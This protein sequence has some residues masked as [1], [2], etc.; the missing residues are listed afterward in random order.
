LIPSNCRQTVS[1][2]VSNGVLIVL[3]W[4]VAVLACVV[5]ENA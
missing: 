5:N 4:V 1:K 2:N 3:V